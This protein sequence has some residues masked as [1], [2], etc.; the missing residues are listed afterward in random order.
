MR[1]VTISQRKAEARS[2]AAEKPGVAAAPLVYPTRRKGAARRRPLWVRPE[3]E[4]IEVRC[5]ADGL[6]VLQR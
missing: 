5:D 4:C 2:A 3:T 6:R 1:A